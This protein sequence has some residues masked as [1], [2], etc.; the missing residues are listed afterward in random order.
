MGLDW[1]IKTD[2]SDIIIFVCKISQRS[3]LLFFLDVLFFL[4]III[5]LSSC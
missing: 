3:S 1:I 5:F 2:V 4:L